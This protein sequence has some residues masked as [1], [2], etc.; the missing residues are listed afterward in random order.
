VGEAISKSM[1][2]KRVMGGFTGGGSIKERGRPGGSRT[3]KRKTSRGRGTKVGHIR[4]KHPSPVWVRSLSGREGVGEGVP[5]SYQR[6]KNCGGTANRGISGPTPLQDL[7]WEKK[8][9]C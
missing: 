2:S 8:S 4:K 3:E 5:E 9:M 7:S 1:Q 6:E